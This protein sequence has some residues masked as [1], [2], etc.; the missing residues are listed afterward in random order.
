MS[1]L[2]E[3]LGLDFMRQVL[4]G[5][6]IVAVLCGYL[7]VF[8]VLRRAVFLGAALAQVSS[9]GVALALLVAGLG[10]AALHGHSP[11]WALPVALLLTVGAASAMA[12]QQRERRVPRETFI[13]VTYA[14]AGA[15]SVLAVALSA[16][17]EAHVMNLLFGNV[18]TISTPAVVG[19]AVLALLV[20]LLHT[21]F[22]KQFLLV[23]FDPEM[24][25]AL[26]YRVRGWDVLLFS[27]IAVTIALAIRAAGA[28]VVFSLLVLPATVALLLGRSVRA[29]VC[30]AVGVALVSAWGGIGLS[31]V[32]DLP[33]GPCVVVVGVV[34]WGLGQLGRLRR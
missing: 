16:G 19:L 27:S 24:G 33:T 30:V 34:F 29:V 6:G 28:L 3:M 20:G 5:T 11:V 9:L 17:G 2:L 32:F 12:L 18:L 26:G 21:L 7:G 15:L 23:S 13:G 31:Y 25:A 8:I 22:F 14:G 10:G 4:L 1:K